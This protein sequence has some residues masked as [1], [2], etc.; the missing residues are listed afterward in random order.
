MYILSLHPEGSYFRTALV[1]CRKG[2]PEIIFLKEF[3]NVGLL[4]KSVLQ[5]V[6]YREKRLEVVSALSSDET[7]IRNFEFPMTQRRKVVKALPFQ[8]ESVLPFSN[9]GSTLLP[10]FNKKKRS[11]IVNLYSY[12]NEILAKH[13]VD[14]NKVGFDPDLVSCVP[15]ALMRFAERYL[16]EIKSLVIFHFTKE[17]KAYM[18]A[19]QNGMIVYSLVIKPDS[20]ERAMESLLKKGLGFEGVLVTG[21]VHEIPKLSLPLLKTK[22]EAKILLYAI[23]IGLA[24]EK[25]RKEEKR[26]QFRVGEFIPKRHLSRLKKRVGVYLGLTTLSSLLALGS[27]NFMFA[28]K[29]KKLHERARYVAELQKEQDGFLNFDPAITLT[30]VNGVDGGLAIKFTSSTE[31]GA[32]E[33][34]SGLKA[35]G[36]MALTKE[37][38]GY[39]ITLQVE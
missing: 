23:E 9:E 11:T 28:F 17:E 38:D 6:R 3:E 26:L 34:A 5:E 4:K 35:L 25:M 31:E 20:I 29:E 24:L 19:I 15:L 33:F 2:E 14:I 16:P 21:V 7:F 27:I 39:K 30:E 1:K 8:L 13:L 12:R 18:V 10:V 36:A 22:L 37:A 32:K